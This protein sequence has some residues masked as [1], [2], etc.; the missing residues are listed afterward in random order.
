MRGNM[1]HAA[2]WHIQARGWCGVTAW[3][4]VVQHDSGS[5]VVR[6]VVVPPA[7]PAAVGH[8]PHGRT[9]ER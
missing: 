7:H 6:P 9:M 1:I 5:R 3:N 4:R 2:G 8:T